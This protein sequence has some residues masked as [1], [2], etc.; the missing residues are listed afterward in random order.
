MSRNVGAVMARSVLR[1]L[2]SPEFIRT[3]DREARAYQVVADLCDAMHP[4]GTVS[5]PSRAQLEQR[6][7]R[8]IRDDA[9]WREFDGRNYAELAEEHGLT[10]KH[11]RYIVE[12]ER[13]QAA[14]QGRDIP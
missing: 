7:D 5:V 11:V 1:T 12:R 2:S 4:L 10:V 6:A 3:L 14:R 9:I 13:W 8:R